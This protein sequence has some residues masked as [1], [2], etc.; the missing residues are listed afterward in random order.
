MMMFIPFAT[1]NDAVQA[2]GRVACGIMPEIG[3]KICTTGH[4]GKNRA[5]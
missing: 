2:T 4:H 5:S 1:N 3:E